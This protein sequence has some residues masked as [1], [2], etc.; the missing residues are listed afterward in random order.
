MGNTTTSPSAGTRRDQ[1]VDFDSPNEM[2]ALL[3]L[4]DPAALARTTRKTKPSLG[5]V[6]SRS[7]ALEAASESLG[8]EGSERIR[9]PLT[10]SPPS[11]PRK[12]HSQTPDHDPQRFRAKRGLVQ[13]DALKDP[14]QGFTEGPQKTLRAGSG[15]DPEHALAIDMLGGTTKS[16]LGEGGESFCHKE[17]GGGSGDCPGII[18]ADALEGE[19]A[20]LLADDARNRTFVGVVD[21]ERS[22]LLATG[23]LDSGDGK[24]GVATEVN[25]AGCRAPR[26]S[27]L[28]GGGKPR[29]RAV[30]ALGVTFDDDVR[31]IDALDILPGS[32]DEDDKT[33]VA[34]ALATASSELVAM[35]RS[36]LGDGVVPVNPLADKG[37][38]DAARERGGGDGLSF[39]SSLSMSTSLRSRRKGEIQSTSITEGL[40]PAAA[41]LVAED[42]SSEEHTQPL[43]SGT[44]PPVGSKELTD[45]AK[46]DLALGFIPSA[47]SGGRKPR[48]SLPQGGRRRA[49]V[50]VSP[51][52]VQGQAAPA[53]GDVK[54][55]AP[56]AA[57]EEE[58]IKTTGIL[59][60]SPRRVEKG[61]V[62]NKNNDA[63]DLGVHGLKHF[64]GESPASKA[65]GPETA[66]VVA[67]T[68][69]V[70][71]PCCKSYIY[72]GGGTDGL[73][74]K[75]GDGGFIRREGASAS[76]GAA[77]YAL[78]VK[79]PVLAS[80]ERQLVLLTAEKERAAA[81]VARDEERLQREVDMAREALKA[82]EARAFEAEAALA[83][84]R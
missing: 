40:S 66:D 41:R 19:K 33:P 81:K 21:E 9:R 7:K 29:P 57:G 42:S 55:M 1:D 75:Q 60:H 71:G 30:S 65:Q 48:R 63:D 10:P 16:S 58:A 50:G 24:N 78:G 56:V 18:I 32:S 61:L 46:L 64:D 53:D 49:Q 31:G 68:A 22:T 34:D 47:M 51:L 45:D 11:S 27:A 82:A 4:T 36:Q 84:A 70:Q 35:P 37:I 52:A 17:D 74:K 12:G 39:P 28:M 69:T 20:E 5:L 23:T 80:L 6:D 72:D 54:S 8:F 73:T 14:A 38:D 13:Q 2:D 25:A 62:Q 79:A 77:G 83:A 44:T 76:A 15:I 43:T 3:Q 59:P 67:S 26:R